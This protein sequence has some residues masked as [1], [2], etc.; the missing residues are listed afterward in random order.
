[1]KNIACFTTLIAL[2]FA[3]NAISKCP[4]VKHNAYFEFKENDKW[5]RC[6][7]NF[8]R[9]SDSW[10]H[11][12]QEIKMS[13]KPLYCCTDT[14][15]SYNFRIAV[16]TCGT[17][18]GMMIMQYHIMATISKQSVKKFRLHWLAIRNIAESTQMYE[19]SIPTKFNTRISKLAQESFRKE[20]SD[21]R[22][23]CNE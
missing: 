14:V 1:M 11:L 19:I 15:D 18:S 17:D 20:I 13:S 5:I 6:H 22:Q 4:Y 16:P 9:N 7:R 2:T 23:V 21:L 10:N 8:D 3:A 12:I